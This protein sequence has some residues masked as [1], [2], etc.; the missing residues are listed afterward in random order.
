[1]SRS[2][3]RTYL[4]EL[5]QQAVDFYLAGKP[6]VE[7]MREYELTL[8]FFDKLIKQAALIFGRKDQ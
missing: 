7:I 5:K 8:Y 6:H 2:Q 4:K 1:M 3:R